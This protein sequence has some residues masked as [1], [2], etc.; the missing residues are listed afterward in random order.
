MWFLLFICMYKFQYSNKNHKCCLHRSANGG[1][2][3][4]PGG[5]RLAGEGER[6][7]GCVLYFF[8]ICF[9]VLAQQFPSQQCECVQL[10]VSSY[11]KKLKTNQINCFWVTASQWFC[12]IVI[13][14]SYIFAPPHKL[15][16][17]ENCIMAEFTSNYKTRW[18]ARG[19]VCRQVGGILSLCTVP[20]PVKGN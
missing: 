5:L 7:R 17:S 6:H 16:C 8:F 13:H 10:F 12:F 14:S 11:S 19:A 15:I 4:R 9:G 2:D 20:H 1:G 18:E 3:C